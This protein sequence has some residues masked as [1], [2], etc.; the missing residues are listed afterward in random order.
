MLLQGVDNEGCH[1]IAQWEVHKKNGMLVALCVLKI[2]SLLFPVDRY[3]GEV[4]YW[5]S[6]LATVRGVI[7]AHIYHEIGKK[8]THICSNSLLF[9]KQ[10]LCSVH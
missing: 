4:S 10:E 2:R 3:N 7:K 1:S 5:E 8:S 6:Q 9:V